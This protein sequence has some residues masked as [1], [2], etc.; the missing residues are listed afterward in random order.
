MLCV[1]T[2]LHKTEYAAFDIPRETNISTVGYLAR[3]S[4]RSHKFVSVSLQ[5]ALNPPPPTL[6]L[7]L[8]RADF[9]RRVCFLRERHVQLRSGD[10]GGPFTS[11]SLVGSSW[12][13]RDLLQGGHL[14]GAPGNSHRHPS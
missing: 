12:Q 13:S 2:V 8:P 4:Y 10:M 3:S 14:G 9:L 11:N 6:R 5:Q 7:P 1:T